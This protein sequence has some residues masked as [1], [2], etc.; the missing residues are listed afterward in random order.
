MEPILVFDKSNL[1][2]KG[3]NSP[4]SY[5]T[6][7]ARTIAKKK[8]GHPT[9]KPLELISWL[10]E[11][12]SDEGDVILDPFLGSGTTAVAALNMGRFFI[13]I[14]QELEHVQTAKN[15]IQEA[16]LKRGA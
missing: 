11:H 13:G 3:K 2:K 10:I 8:Y 9:T 1:T 12:Y 14:E 4:Y 15:R 7:Q 6:F 5:S 16:Q